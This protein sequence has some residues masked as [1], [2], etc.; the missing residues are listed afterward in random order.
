MRLLILLSPIQN[1]H[2][3][4]ILPPKKKSTKK[5]TLHGFVQ[6]ARLYLDKAR[7]T[8]LLDSFGE[9]FP[10]KENRIEFDFKNK[11]KFGLPKPIIYFKYNE[12]R[13]K[14]MW[15]IQNQ[16][17]KKTCKSFYK[18]PYIKKKKN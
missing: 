18:L 7:Q 9:M 4:F 8:S 11:N 13:R 5:E 16:N 15:K 10:R 6:Y 12:N 3:V 1:S 17:I 14:L 2:G